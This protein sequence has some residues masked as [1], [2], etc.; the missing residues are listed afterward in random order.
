MRPFLRQLM[1]A[2]CVKVYFNIPMKVLPTEGAMSKNSRFNFE[3]FARILVYSFV[4]VLYLVLK[5]FIGEA[6]RG[7]ELMFGLLN[8]N[9][10]TIISDGLFFSVLLMILSKLFLAEKNW[11][12]STIKATVEHFDDFKTYLETTFQLG[13]IRILVDKDEWIKERNRL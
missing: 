12:E 13:D 3:S 2:L 6:E 9:I 4:L 11:K 10:L 8:K 7:N 1:Q 5:Y